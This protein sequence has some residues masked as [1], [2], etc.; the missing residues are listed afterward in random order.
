MGKEILIS[1]PECLRALRLLMG[2]CYIGAG[3]ASRLCSAE[4]QIWALTR[5]RSSGTS[6]LEAGGMFAYNKDLQDQDF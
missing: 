4:I 6:V 2:L 1:L 5:K 3:G